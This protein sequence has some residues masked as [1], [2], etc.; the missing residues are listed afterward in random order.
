LYDPEETFKSWRYPNFSAPDVRFIVWLISYNF[1]KERIRKLGSTEGGGPG[2]YSM[3][4]EGFASSR[5]GNAET[6]STLTSQTSSGAVTRPVGMSV[7]KSMP[8]RIM[9]QSAIGY[10]HE[11]YWELIR[12]GVLLTIALRTGFGAALIAYTANRFYGKKSSKL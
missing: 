4:E 5:A 3:I 10:M 9:R 12:R 6:G 2:V 8:I 7:E 11:G 1:R